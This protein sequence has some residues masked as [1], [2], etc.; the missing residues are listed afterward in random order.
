MEQVI[1]QVQVLSPTR[2]K[3]GTDCPVLRYCKEQVLSDTGPHL[4]RMWSELAHPG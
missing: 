1:H 3:A 4:A 2:K